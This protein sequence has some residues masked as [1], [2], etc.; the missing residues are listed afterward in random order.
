MMSKDLV[1]ILVLSVT[2][3]M[4]EIVLIG[5]FPSVIA[6]GMGIDETEL[7]MNQTMNNQSDAAIMSNETAAISNQSEMTNATIA[8]PVN[9]TGNPI[10]DTLKD[11]FDR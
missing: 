9:E 8:T 5:S 6:Q 1:N 3:L 10:V 2:V 11:M 7:I 4:G